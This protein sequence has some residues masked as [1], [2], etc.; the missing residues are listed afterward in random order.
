MGKFVVERRWAARTSKSFSTT[1]NGHPTP[2]LW[3]FCAGQG[4]S[5]ATGIGIEVTREHGNVVL[6]NRTIA[7]G[8]KLMHVPTRTLYTTQSVPESFAS[9]KQR[10]HLPVHALLAAC[11][12]FGPLDYELLEYAPW[13]S[14]WPQLS[15]FTTSMPMFW[16]DSCLKHKA[17]TGSRSPHR[18]SSDSFAILPPPITGSWL[19][20][21]QKDQPSPKGSTS[22][23]S[24]Q[25]K[26]LKTHLDSVAK[27][28]PE[29]ASSLNDPHDPT[30]WHF[31]HNWCCVNTRCFYYVA[32]GLK[33]P[34]DPNEAM[35]MCPGMDMFNHT[36]GPGCKTTYD[37]SGYSVIADREYK[38]GEEILLSYGPH[39]NDV[40]WAEY[41][42]MLDGNQVDAIRIDKLVL[43]DLN[44][45]QK[46][47]LAEYGY[48][49]E[50]WLQMDGTCY[51]AEIAAK[52]TVFSE[53]EWIRMVQEGVDPT[54]HQQGKPRV[55]RKAG[56]TQVAVRRDTVL[57][58]VK[59]KQVE[60]I[61][62][63]KVEAEASIGGLNAMSAR[64]V[65]DI[66]A[67]HAMTMK[68]QGIAEADTETTRS[69]QAS[70]RHVMCLK[71]WRQIW[72]LCISAL[73]SIED[74]C[75]GSFIISDSGRTQK[76]LDTTVE[77]IIS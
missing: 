18:G 4:I 46:D 68:A 50:Y 8:Q 59:S 32:P 2:S 20:Q 24:Q 44:D 5:I 60:W 34:S 22:L 48:L 71:R 23:I 57:G 53:T 61:L 66:F 63:A 30:Y 56:G 15:D 11:L 55:K 9:V 13:M 69:K 7:K 42:F 65:L 27:I 64:M 58:K 35:A 12:T 39:N 28:L 77:G 74:E 17:T 10:K 29:H 73:R 16:P 47:L 36:D 62:K 26:K 76:D 14:M 75:A 49:G 19:L 45:K 38:V 72:Q 33:K 37:R 43:D 52:V 3:G 67:D 54:D 21:A 41:G 25:S 31:V 51:T 6:A 40:L 1:M 70:Q